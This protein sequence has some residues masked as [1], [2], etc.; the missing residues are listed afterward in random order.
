MIAKTYAD[1][2]YDFLIAVD[3]KN[4]GFW[5]L[6]RAVTMKYKAQIYLGKEKQQFFEQWNLLGGGAN[7]SV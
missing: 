5:I 6:P 3:C 4:R 2:G 7:Q 1:D